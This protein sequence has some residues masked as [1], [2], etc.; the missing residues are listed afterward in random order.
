MKLPAFALRNL[1]LRCE[2]LALNIGVVDRGESLLVNLVIAPGNAFFV[3]D[4][5]RR[6]DRRRFVPV[7]GIAHRQP[8]TNRGDGQHQSDDPPNC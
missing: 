3:Q 8:R 2:Y 5:L 7:S 1:F 4:L 6:F